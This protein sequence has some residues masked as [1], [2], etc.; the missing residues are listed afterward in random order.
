[1]RSGQ[2]TFS[3]E[4]KEVKA[5]ALVSGDKSIVIKLET[6]EEAALALQQF[7]ASEPVVVS[8]EGT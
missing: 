6:T 2:I 7:I 1:M 3:A 5:R 8:V 4:V